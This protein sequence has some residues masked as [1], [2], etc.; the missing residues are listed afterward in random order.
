LYDSCYRCPLSVYI[1]VTVDDKLERLVIAGSPSRAELEEARLK[2]ITE[3]SEL[4]GNRETQVFNEILNSYYKQR[5]LIVGLE[6]SLR[7][8]ACGRFDAATEYL[9]KNGV[10]CS[11]PGSDEDVNALVEKVQVKLKVYNSNLIKINGQCRPLMKKGEKPTRK[12]YNRLLITLS[13][14]EVIKMQLNPN[15]MTVAEFAEYLNMFNEYQNLLIM[16]RNG[17]H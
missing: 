12:Y 9:N 3:F 7:L 15:K 13:T 5:V 8:I 10:R 1:D 16:K 4:S 6:A 2:L 11:V 17:K 14:C